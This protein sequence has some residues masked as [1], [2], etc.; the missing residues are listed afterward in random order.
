MSGVRPDQLQAL[1]LGGHDFVSTAN[2]TLMRI[3]AN[4]LNILEKLGKLLGEETLDGS[5]RTDRPALE[6][7]G[8]GNGS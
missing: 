4:Q 8:D 7:S 2:A 3:E 6:H 5:N 1:I